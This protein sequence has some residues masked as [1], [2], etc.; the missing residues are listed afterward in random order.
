[1][2]LKQME[3]FRAVMLTG[4]VSQAAK[5]LYRTQPAVSMMLSSLEEEIGFELFERRKKRLYPTPE[6][7]YL[8]KEV[9]EIFA[10]INDVSQTVQD[11][12]NKQY[13]FLRIGCMPGPSTFFIP[14]L[15]ADFLDHHPKVQVSL[16]TRTSKSVREWVASSQY[17]IGL[18]E[19]SSQ[20]PGIDNEIFTMSCVCALPADHPLAVHELITPELLDAEPLITLHPDHMTFHAIQAA[21]E[22]AGY[23]MN[24]RL[25][26]RFFIPAF[27]FVERGLGICIMDP[28]SINSYCSY[29]RPG[30]IAFR[31]FEPD[32]PLKFGIL[33]PAASP[34][35]RIT[36]EFSE[37]LTERILEVGAGT[38]RLLS[39]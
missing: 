14:D 20:E 23:R 10:R 38:D 31:R 17:D 26:T 11:I 34:R 9:E 4:S 33:Y 15:V 5:Q 25:Q 21:F 19:A 8:Y 7:D 22:D 28:L 37:Q 6:A 24:V 35:S 29:A 3:A 16:Q 27:R 2:N 36:R 18:A 1:M 39:W 30:K 12:Q 13:G 32:I